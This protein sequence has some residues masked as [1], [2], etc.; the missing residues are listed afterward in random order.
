MDGHLLLLAELSV[1][2]AGFSSVVVVFRKHASPGSWTPENAYRF[3][4]ML[5]SSLAGGFFSILPGAISGLGLNSNGLWSLV[6]G[7]LLL[8][9]SFDLFRRTRMIRGFRVNLPLTFT[10]LAF[11]VVAITV[12]IL[13]IGNLLIPHGVGPYLF[14]VSWLVVNSGLMFYILVF[15]PAS[16][17]E[18]DDSTAT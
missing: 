14:G 8:Y 6:S 15:S 17:D 18:S 11:I 3:R 4:I 13:N 1:G 9:L 5:E 10:I 7:A 2:L 16:S 12:Q